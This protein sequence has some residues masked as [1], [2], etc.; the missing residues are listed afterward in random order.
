MSIY[1]YDNI[2]KIAKLTTRELPHL[3]KTAKITV[4]ENNGVYSMTSMNALLIKVHVWC[5]PN[6]QVSEF[7]VDLSVT[8]TSH[9][10]KTV[11]EHLNLQFN[12]LLEIDIKVELS[13]RV[14]HKHWPDCLGQVKFR[15]GQA[16]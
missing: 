4:R 6:L 2:S 13:F 9:N 16:F 1:I 3:A 15:F 5:S 11:H 12:F 7:L 10:C 14:L 8:R